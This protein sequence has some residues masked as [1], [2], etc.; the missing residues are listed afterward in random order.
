M[1]DIAINSGASPY[2]TAEQ[3]TNIEPYG[4]AWGEVSFSDLMVDSGVSYEFPG[5]EGVQESSVIEKVLHA[6]HDIDT[7]RD[8]I[9][10]SMNDTIDA[11]SSESQLDVASKALGSQMQALLESQRDANLHFFEVQN[12]LQESRNEFGILTEQ[13]AWVREIAKKGVDSVNK[14]VSNQ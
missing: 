11:Y 3:S 10:V 7:V 14:V 9:S 1:S 13:A 8:D 6:M 5:V 2:S 4:N 12:A